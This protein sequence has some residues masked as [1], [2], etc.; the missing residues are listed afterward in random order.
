TNPVAGEPA[1][2]DWQLV[3]SPPNE[4]VNGCD[5]V[6]RPGGENDAVPLSWHPPV[7]AADAPCANVNAHSTAATA[8]R[9]ATLLRPLIFELPCP[10][11]TGDG[12]PT[13]LVQNETKQTLKGSVPLRVGEASAPP[14]R[15]LT[16]SDRPRHRSGHGQHRVRGRALARRAPGGAR[17]RRDRHAARRTARAAARAYPRARERPDPRA[18]AGGAGRGGT[19]LRQ[20]RPQRVRGRTGARGRSSFRRHGRHTVL[21]VHAAG[22]E[23]GGVR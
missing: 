6:F 13:R 3:R 21:L 1:S 12:G 22:G 23:A 7:L 18:R 17:R 2:V 15:I 14:R 20:E 4:Y 8:A 10:L 19:L 16:I 11:T 9:S 5:V